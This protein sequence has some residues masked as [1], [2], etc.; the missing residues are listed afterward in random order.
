MASK[1]GT[2]RIDHLAAAQPDLYLWRGILALILTGLFVYCRFTFGNSSATTFYTPIYI[3]IER[4]GQV[5]AS[6]RDN[7]RMLMV[8]AR[9]IH[10]RVWP[11]DADVTDGTTPQPGGK[12]IPLALSSPPCRRAMICFTSDPERY[13]IDAPLR[14]ISRVRFTVATAFIDLYQLPLLFGLAIIARSSSRFPSARTFDGASGLRYGRRLK[15]PDLMTPKEFN[16]GSRGWHR[17]QDQR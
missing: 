2:Q 13:Y 12:P 6:R 3:R 17:H 1:V 7:Y 5:S 15:G 10:D 9:G 11:R 14:P 4:C 16:E 8:G